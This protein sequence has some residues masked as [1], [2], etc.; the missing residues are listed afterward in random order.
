MYIRLQLPVAGYGNVW[1]R[2]YIPPCEIATVIYTMVPAIEISRWFTIED[3][4]RPRPSRRSRRSLD[5]WKSSILIFRANSR[6]ISAGVL[7]FTK[8]LVDYYQKTM[9]PTE[10]GE[11][12]LFTKLLEAEE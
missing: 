3:L 7:S 9:G 5:C 12:E 8:M 11:Q 2:I 4:L 10:D 6:A 1:L